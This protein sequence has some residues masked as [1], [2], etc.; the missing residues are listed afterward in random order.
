MK[1]ILKSFILFLFITSPLFVT[2]GVIV[3]DSAA[4]GANTGNNWNNAF[5]N[6]QDAINVAVSGDRIWVAKGTY[7]P[8]QDSTGNS[9]PMDNRMKTFLL[10]DG[11]KLFGGFNGSETNQSQRNHKINKSILSGDIG[12]LND[13]LDN[14]YRII[15]GYNL[16]TNTSFS[17]FYIENANGD[18]ATSLGAGLYLVDCEMNLT[19]LVVRDN[20]T[21]VAGA[22]TLIGSSIVIKNSSFIKNSGQNAVLLDR[23]DT[24]N[25]SVKIVNCLFFRN[26]SFRGVYRDSIGFE[27]INCNFVQNKYYLFYNATTDT[28]N[29]RNCIFWENESSI[30]VVFDV[31]TVVLYSCVFP[32]INEQSNIQFRGNCTSQQPRFVDIENLNFNVSPCSPLIDAGSNDQYPY[33]GD[34]DYELNPRIL[35]GQIDIGAVEFTG[36]TINKSPITLYVDQSATGSGDGL[37][38]ANAYTSLKTALDDLATLQDCVIPSIYVAEGIY[39]ASES[40]DRTESFVLN[41]QFT[42]LGG[43]PSGGGFLISRNPATNV[44]ILSGEIG[45]I[46][47]NDNTAQILAIEYADSTSRLDGF[48]IQDG[49]NTYLD[50]EYICQVLSS[51]IAF[52][53]LVVRNNYSSADGLFRLSNCGFVT[54][55]QSR[56]DS[57]DVSRVLSNF[58][59]HTEIEDCSFLSNEG[60]DMFINGYISMK[61]CSI[62]KGDFTDLFDNVDTII[63]SNTLIFEDVYHDVFEDVHYL[64]I[65]NSTIHVEAN[66]IINDVENYFDTASI[67]IHNSIISGNIEQELSKYVDGPIIYDIRNSMLK[68]KYPGEINPIEGPPRFQDVINENFQLSPCSNGIN[69]GDPALYGGGSLDLNGQN[70]FINQI[71]IGPFENQVGVSNPKFHINI[72][73]DSSATGNGSG[74]SWQNARTDLKPALDQIISA[75]GCAIVDSVFVA[76]GTF[77]P[78]SSDFSDR[79]FRIQYDLVLLGGFP[80]GG[81]TLEERDYL[82]NPTILSPYTSEVLFTHYLSSSSRISGFHFKQSEDKVWEDF[83][84]ELRFDQNIISQNIKNVSDA[85][86][87]NLIDLTFS[88]LSIED[89][90]FTQNNTNQVIFTEGPDTISIINSSFISNTGKESGVINAMSPLV[91]KDCTFQ[92]NQSTDGGSGVITTD[93]FFCKITNSLFIQNHSITEG[94]AIQ[95]K[96]PMNIQNCIFDNNSSVDAGG[97]IFTTASDLQIINSLFTQ[98]NGSTSGGAFRIGHTCSLDKC[99]RHI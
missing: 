63:L 71:D 91:I 82:L 80:T 11:V 58:W 96:G 61:D 76:K 39:K 70:R 86:P 99:L 8:S 27:A 17:G 62:K 49:Y 81:S 5:I 19:N 22:L 6:L 50:D 29:L 25:D 33:I 57:N 35:N 64:S 46:S 53:N 47:D 15:S 66:H 9:S 51:N 98:N 48:F 16:G 36:T 31:N 34:T 87:D 44:T 72:Y 43:F 52:S 7:F 68:G 10:K 94:G 60:G 97:A 79:K 90:T 67:I 74:L 24:Y 1:Q 32:A 20:Y 38:W 93:T 28:L 26:S 40:S 42:M 3:V 92:N 56:I 2:A 4:T 55:D 45:G 88:H 37:T 65:N 21:L 12:I 85:F 73:V 14:C 78:E 13:S 41:Q 95:S 54:F 30:A 18:H 69:A 84:S 75:S 83:Q 89:C 59:S 77:I 23:G